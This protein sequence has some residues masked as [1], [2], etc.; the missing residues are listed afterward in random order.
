M[1]NQVEEDA[2]CYKH[3]SLQESDAYLHQEP[4]ELHPS[5]SEMTEGNKFTHHNGFLMA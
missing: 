4:S 5:D 3:G 2:A 1:Y